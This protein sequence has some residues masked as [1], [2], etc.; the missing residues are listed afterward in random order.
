MKTRDSG[1]RDDAAQVR[2]MRAQG[3]G[4]AAETVAANDAHEALGLVEGE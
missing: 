1:L 3:F 2:L 4:S